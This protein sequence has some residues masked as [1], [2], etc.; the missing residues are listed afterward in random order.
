[1]TSSSGLWSLAGVGFIF[2]A[3]IIAALIAALICGILSGVKAG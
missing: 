2:S 1:M 3:F